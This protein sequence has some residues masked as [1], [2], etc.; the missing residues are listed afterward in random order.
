M[1]KNGVPTYATLTQA[2]EAM[3]VSGKRI[4]VRIRM[5][6]T[7]TDSTPKLLAVIVNAVVVTEPKF[8]YLLPVRID[9]RDLNG[10]IDSEL[11]TWEKVRQLDTWCGTARPL[12]MRC[13]NP[14]YHNRDVFLMPVPA[15]P[16]MDAQ[17]VGTEGEHTYTLSL[18]VQEA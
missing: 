12:R 10:E 3:G 1:K 7:D 14:L 4:R 9:E 13:V 16:L 5:Y 2:A 17:R 11:K 15:R 18:A 6:S 8:A